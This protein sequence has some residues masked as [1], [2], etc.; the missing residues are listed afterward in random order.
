M[1]NWFRI[2]APEKIYSEKDQ[3]EF[4]DLS[5][6]PKWFFSQLAE[7][8]ILIFGKRKPFIFHWKQPNEIFYFYVKLQTYSLKTDINH[9]LGKI[10]FWGFKAKRDQNGPE[11]SSSIKIEFNYFLGKTFLITPIAK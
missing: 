11:L 10:L 7:V 3:H 1:D 4:H 9:F 5:L 8:N 6:F 2:T